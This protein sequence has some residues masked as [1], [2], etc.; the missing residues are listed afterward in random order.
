MVETLHI[1]KFGIL[2]MKEILKKLCELVKRR[3]QIRPGMNYYFFLCKIDK[4]CCILVMRVECCALVNWSFHCLGSMLIITDLYSELFN[5]E[6]AL[7]II[8][9]A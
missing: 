5:M 2:L 1:G 8:L 3:H 6:Q 9:D 4:I 7:L